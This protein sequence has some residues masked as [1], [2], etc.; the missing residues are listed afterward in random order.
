MTK[1]MSTPRAE[2]SGA[3]DAEE[4]LSRTETRLLGLPPLDFWVSLPSLLLLTS[5][6]PE[7]SA[8][9]VDTALGLSRPVEPHP[10]CQACE[11]VDLN[12]LFNLLKVLYFCI[13]FFYMK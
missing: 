8:R 2:L 11:I 5:L 1:A 13:Y 12:L 4:K 7:N 3:D 6:A 10:L 9:G